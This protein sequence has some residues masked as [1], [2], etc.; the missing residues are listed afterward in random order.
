LSV[1]LGFQFD[2]HRTEFLRISPLFLLIIVDC[3]AAVFQR[4]PNPNKPKLE[5]FSARENNQHAMYTLWRACN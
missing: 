4:L 3:A 1:L 2:A 5:Y